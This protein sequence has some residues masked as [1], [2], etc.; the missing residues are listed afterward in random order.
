MVTA[1]FAVLLFA[2]LFLASSV[3]AH[4]SVLKQAIS[5]L[6]EDNQ[7]LDETLKDM[8]E[9]LHQYEDMHERLRTRI[10]DMTAHYA[11]AALRAASAASKAA[12]WKQQHARAQAANVLL[13]TQAHVDRAR[14]QARDAYI[15][16]LEG[17]TMVKVVDAA[18]LFGHLG[19][20]YSDP[21][22]RSGRV[23]HRKQREGKP[24]PVH[25]PRYKGLRAH[26]LGYGHLPN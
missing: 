13:L 14:I 22:H 3:L 25:Q 7:L 16:H 17:R 18:D 11:Q 12:F 2:V 8:R 23:P 10:S 19:Q 21:T 24:R 9:S 5:D 1:I 26:R 4:R 20:A 15:D 6:E